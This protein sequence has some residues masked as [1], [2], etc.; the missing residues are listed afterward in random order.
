MAV[1]WEHLLLVKVKGFRDYWVMGTLGLV[2]SSFQA[3]LPLPLIV[4]I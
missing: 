1:I 3:V 4:F 2:N